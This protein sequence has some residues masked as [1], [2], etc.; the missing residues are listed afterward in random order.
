[1]VLAKNITY[2]AIKT[3]IQQLTVNQN[4]VRWP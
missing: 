1:V 4:R 3:S 2:E